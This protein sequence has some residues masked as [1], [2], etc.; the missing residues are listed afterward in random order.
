[1]VW[2]T[3]V[4]PTVEI[5]LTKGPLEAVSVWTDITTDVRQII[6][7]RGRQSINTEFDA[8]TLTVLLDNRLGVYDPNNTQST[9]DPNLK[10]GVPIRVQ[11]VHNA[12]TYNLFYGHITEWGLDYAAHP[13]ATVT[14]SCLDNMAL[15][16]TGQLTNV[17][18]SQESSDTRLGNILDSIGWHITQYRWK[19]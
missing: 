5:G 14:L 18:Y 8:G 9:H 16:R 17:T 10:L 1:M 4:T 6:P 12:V 3:N 19:I 13:D 11:M 7:T 2:P 15:L